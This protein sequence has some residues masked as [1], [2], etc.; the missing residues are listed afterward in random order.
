MK[1][2]VNL[3]N[4]RKAFED[5]NRSSHFSYEGLEILFDWLEE[6]EQC[7]GV[8]EE[9]DVI[10]LCC[11]FAEAT[12]IEIAKDYAID[13]NGLDDDDTYLS[14]KDYLE[15]EGVYLGLTDAGS[16]VYRQH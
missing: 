1:V 2:T 6:L 14:V 12:P 15:S 11:D 8:Q 5:C 13:I 7:S 4:F 10:G 16:I 9:L 3:S